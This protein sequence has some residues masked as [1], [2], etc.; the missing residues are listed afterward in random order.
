MTEPETWGLEHKSVD[1]LL[2]I[3]QMRLYRH[4][5][6]SSWKLKFSKIACKN[7]H[8]KHSFYADWYALK[9]MQIIIDRRLK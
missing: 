1:E 9:A 2:A 3:V 8:F 4:H 6:K 5:W 7:N